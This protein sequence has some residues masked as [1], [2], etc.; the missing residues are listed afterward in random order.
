MLDLGISK[1]AIADAINV[2]YLFSVYTRLADSMGW[3]VP[4]DPAFFK[5]VA[6]RLLG[7]GYE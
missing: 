3:D 5:G 6:K 2:A 7:H 1:E 4:S